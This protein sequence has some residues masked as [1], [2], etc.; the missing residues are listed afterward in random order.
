MDGFGT[1]PVFRFYKEAIGAERI[2]LAVVEDDD[3]L[4]FVKK[5][6]I[7][8]LRSANEKIIDTIKNIGCKTTA[9]EIT[10]YRKVADKSNLSELLSKH[11]IKVPKQYSIGEIEDGKT[12]F[13]KPKNGSD[14]MGV[15]L[16]SICKSK[17]DVE[18]QISYICNEI[19]DEA[20][21][22]DFIEGTDCT[23]ACWSSLGV[24]KACT[25]EV[26]CEET[27]SIQTRDCKVGF[28]ECCRALDDDNLNN[29]A[30]GLFYFL[31]IK[32]HARMDFRKGLD[33]E[34]Y[35]IDVNLLPG[36]GPIDHFAKCLLLDK[37]MSYTDSM[38]AIIN[39]ASTL[40]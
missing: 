25:I 19:K 32:H 12:Y 3:S 38:W 33:G 16:Q 15:T 37:N 17:E 23:V 30:R 6:D 14:S 20:I 22:E 8:L 18:R 35:L 39:S 34:Y 1:S 31:D 9:E 5:D 21:I 2:N 26:I 29:L 36:L 4:D 40:K 13:V 28:K 24:I 10:T 27:Q 7:V 11:G